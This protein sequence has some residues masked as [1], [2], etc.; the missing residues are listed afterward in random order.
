MK[1]INK[2]IKILK[3]FFV[4]HR[5]NAFRPHALRHKAISIYSIGLILS[6]LLLGVT[7]YSGPVV[8]AAEAANLSKNIVYYTNLERKEQGLMDLSEN[9]KL[10]LAAKDKLDDMFQKNYWDHNGPKG[11]TAWDFIANEGYFYQLAGENLARGFTN[12]EETISAWMASQSH[13][14]NILNNRFSEIGVAAGSGKING[15]QTTVVV[16]LFGEPKTA[17]A[18]AKSSNAGQFSAK[19]VLPE[20]KLANA[21]QPSKAPFVMIWALLFGLILLDGFMI[22]RLGLHFSKA[23]VF[24]MRV[25]LLAALAGIVFLMFGFVAIA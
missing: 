13:K 14:A 5:G 24:N 10:N 18:A 21:T 1:K 22:R 15:A 7:A 9:V 12:S 8:S 20:I 19:E 2:H 23:H 3:H 25:S 4:P 11:E 17:Y 6:Q 16:Q